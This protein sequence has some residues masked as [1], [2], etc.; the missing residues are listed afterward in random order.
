MFR[1]VID[2]S[3]EELIQFDE[4]KRIV[5]YIPTNNDEKECDPYEGYDNCESENE[6]EQYVIV[7]VF[8]SATTLS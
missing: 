1:N 4:M 8:I 6:E 3:K 2:M 7:P 5:Y